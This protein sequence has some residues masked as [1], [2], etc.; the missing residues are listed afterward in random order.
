MD[1]LTIRANTLAEHTIRPK[2]F[3]YAIRANR[4]PALAQVVMVLQN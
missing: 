1:K 2:R 3:N 4:L